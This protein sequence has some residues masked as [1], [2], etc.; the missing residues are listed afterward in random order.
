M[1]HSDAPTTAPRRLLGALRSQQ[2]LLALC[3]FS[4]TLPCLIF[5]FT[6]P[7]TL[8]EKVCDIVLP[9]S[10]Y[11]VAMTYAR[12]P[13]KAYW[14]MF[15]FVFFGAFQIVLLD[16]YGES[17][18][19][20]DMYINLVTTNS[21]EA[22]EQLGG[23][24]GGV[25]FIV[26]LYVPLLVWSAMTMRGP[27]LSYDS[28]MRQRRYA[29]MGLAL[30]VLLLASCYI[31][32]PGYSVLNDIFPVNVI[33]NLRLACQ[34]YYNTSRYADTSAGF[35][36]QASPTHAG[37]EREVYIL[38]IG[39]T[40]RADNFGLYGYR[41]NTT[42]LLGKLRQQG[43]LIVCPDA[44]TE[45][46]VTHKSVPMILSAVSAVDFDRIYSQKSIITAFSEAGFHTSFFSNQLPNHSFI[47]FFGD[48]ADEHLFIKAGKKAGANIS[49]DQLLPLVRRALA[50]TAHAK[51]LIVLHTYGS[52]FNYSDRYPK[53]FRQYT[54][55][56]FTSIGAANRK[57]MIN[58]YDNA[59]LYTD[60]LLSRII[61]QADSTRAPA[62]VVYLSDHGEDLYDDAR[63]RYMH[64]SPIPTYY[65]L[66]VPLLFWTSE[67]YRNAHPAQHAALLI[68]RGKPVSTNLTVFHT[69]LGLS[70]IDTPL[71][72][73]KYSLC[74][75]NYCPPKRTYLNDHNE[76]LPLD[77]VGL[78]PEDEAAMRAR[79]IA[80]P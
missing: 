9:L 37:S 27:G 3:V 48:E 61:A 52:H 13:G 55:D 22:G 35:T 11:W 65:Q 78:R 74:S 31:S 56:K 2:A 54:P 67:A 12:A 42:P 64:A 32:V 47:D 72:Q 68:N 20:V 14:C 16:I 30:G 10:A 6:E 38:V 15:I 63:N 49:D 40:A 70:G 21:A 69:L 17:I 19:A 46:N 62:C 5:F 75:G 8:L 36:F 44:L 1:K 76:D 53:R 43:S 51:R 45:A 57:P 50:D 28:R 59:I 18:I 71:R 41:R 25:I 39:E 73:D 34:R 77:Q 29:R 23:I 60:Y 66:H 79:H 7:S 26:V 4:L 24:I 33:N 80:Y 58:A